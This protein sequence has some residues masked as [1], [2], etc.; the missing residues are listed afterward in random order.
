MLAAAIAV[1]LGAEPPSPLAMCFSDDMVL[2]R[3]PKSARLFGTVSP[4]ATVTV[5]LQPSSSSRS[6]IAKADADGD[7]VASLPPQPAS[8]TSAGSRITVTTVSATGDDGARPVTAVL[9][10]V[11]F[12]DVLLVTGL[13]KH[14]CSQFLRLIFLIGAP[15]L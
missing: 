6:V 5:S 15:V 3:E 9:S 4:G 2:Q 12:G 13:N 10:N 14:T 7:W 8:V 11:L 1:C